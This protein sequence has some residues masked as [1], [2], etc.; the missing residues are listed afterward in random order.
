[1]MQDRKLA[2]VKQQSLAMIQLQRLYAK[3]KRRRLTK[4]PR[5]LFPHNAERE[6]YKYLMMIVKEIESQVKRLLI[7]QIPQL[8]K[9]AQQ[10]RPDDANVRVDGFIE[11]LQ[12]IFMVISF[13]VTKYA[14]KSEDI[15][16]RVFN[17]VSQYNYTQFAKIARAVLG[18]DVFIQQP[19]LTDELKL[20]G[21]T[22][23]DLIKSIPQQG[24][25]RIQ[26]ATL[27]ALRAG[28]RAES[29]TD[30]ITHS[31]GVTQRRAKLIARDQVGKLNGQLTKLRQNELG[32]SQYIWRTSEDERVRGDPDGKYP[33]ADP[34]HYA[35]NGRKY[36]WNNPPEDGNP[37]EPVQCRCIAEPVFGNLINEQNYN[38]KK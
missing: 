32:I 18:V 14:P 20:F 22:N 1:M 38:V 23:V 4:P 10:L 33:N 7:P 6:Y 17:I 12:R 5:W 11:E 21:Q 37:G 3:N 35:R 2:D 30:M 13:N 16:T 26:Q 19:W 29:L 9:D 15:A 34:S 36:S 27:N 24:L 31:F 28:T 8:I 25:Q